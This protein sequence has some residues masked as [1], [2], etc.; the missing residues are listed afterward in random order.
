MEM[1][2]EATGEPAG[3]VFVNYCGSEENFN[4]FVHASITSVLDTLYLENNDALYRLSIHAAAFATGD[5]H[6]IHITAWEEK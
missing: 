4:E 5:H 6:E 2:Y 1:P 3:R